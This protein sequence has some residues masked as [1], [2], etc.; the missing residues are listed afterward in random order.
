MLLREYDETW[1]KI[2]QELRYK[3][4]AATT[5]GYTFPENTTIIKDEY[6]KSI[7]K[8]LSEIKILVKEPTVTL[9]ITV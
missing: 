8:L 6:K 4:L 2:V 5:L 1:S 9:S 7:F 3:L